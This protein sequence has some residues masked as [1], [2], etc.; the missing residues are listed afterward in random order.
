M[1]TKPEGRRSV[2]LRTNHEGT[3]GRT[4]D[5]HLE[6]ADEPV[7]ADDDFVGAP[8]LVVLDDLLVESKHLHLPESG[9]RRTPTVARKLR[10][11]LCQKVKNT[12]DF[13]P[14]HQHKVD[15]HLKRA[16]ASL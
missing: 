7:E 16:R 9:M 10:A 4:E 8:V 5:H 2:S 11:E 14:R 6:T 13:P 15:T 3:N 1:W 12:T